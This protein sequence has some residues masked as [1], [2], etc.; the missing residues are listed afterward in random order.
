[1]TS[2]FLSIYHVLTQTLPVISSYDGSWSIEPNWQQLKKNSTFVFERLCV[3]CILRNT[4]ILSSFHK[5]CILTPQAFDLF[6]SIVKIWFE[7]CKL[8]WSCITGKAV[9]CRRGSWFKLF[10]F[11]VQSNFC[12]RLWHRSLYRTLA[13]NLANTENL[14]RNSIIPFNTHWKYWTFYAFG[15]DN[16]SLSA[17]ICPYVPQM[18]N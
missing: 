11:L 8:N 2:H 10:E 5:Y 6:L 17:L 9:L 12:V 16:T 15:L 1:M 14:L 3:P 18:L 4:H 7:W 13:W